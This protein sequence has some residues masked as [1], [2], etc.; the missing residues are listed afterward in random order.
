MIVFV[1]LVVLVGRIVWVFVGV[2]V[3]V[4][5]FVTDGVNVGVG[6]GRG[7]G[8]FPVIVNLPEIF[9][10]IPLNICTSYS[11]GNHSDGSGL[12]SV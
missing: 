3:G 9:Q 1:A 6:V 2:R 10:N 7:V 4:G 11:P 5:V 8:A 12:Q